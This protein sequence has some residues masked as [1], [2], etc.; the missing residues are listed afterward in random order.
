MVYKITIKQPNEYNDTTWDI[1]LDEGKLPFY[2]QGVPVRECFCTY[3]VYWEEEENTGYSVHFKSYLTDI[4]EESDN[5]VDVVEATEEES[6]YFVEMV[7]KY[8]D[9]MKERN[10][11][12]MVI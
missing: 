6:E 7:R 10:K 2:K 3:E 12:R 11:R 4:K 8:G 9:L 5:F 1:Y